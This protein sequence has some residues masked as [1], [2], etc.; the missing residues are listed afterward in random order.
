[1]ISTYFGR[2][3]DRRRSLQPG[4][5]APKN[6]EEHDFIELKFRTAEESGERIPP[7][8][9]SVAAKLRM[10]AVRP[11]LWKTHTE[12]GFEEAIRRMQRDPRSML[13]RKR[14]DSV[15]I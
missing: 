1:M 2:K 14:P 7:A 11:F 9:E 6:N 13:R 15:S 4:P 5:D 8:R 10:Q 12:S 3:G